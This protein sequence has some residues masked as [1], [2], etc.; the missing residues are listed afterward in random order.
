MHTSAI[1]KFFEVPELVEQLG[2]FL[3]PHD[4]AQLLR[5]SHGLY[6]ATIPHFWRYID[7]EDDHRVD[8]LITSPEA[9]EALAKNAPF[10][11]TLKAGF[12]FMSY[13]FER[14]ARHLD[15]HEQGENGHAS[16]THS[17]VTTTATTTTKIERPRWLPKAIVRTPPA[18]PLPP[19]TQLTQLDVFFG[20]Q[21]RGV[22][23]D[24][25]MRIN[26]AIPLLLPLSW[27]MNLNAP[28][29]THVCFRYM[30]PPEPLELRCL[31]RSLSRLKNLTHLRIEMFSRATKTWLSE[32]MVPVIFFACPPS[33]VSIRM[34]TNAQISFDEEAEEVRLRS[35]GVQPELRE[36][37]WE[38]PD[39]EEPDWDEGDLVPREEP[40]ESLKDLVLPSFRMGYKASYV[41]RIMGHC[42]GLESWD[43]PCLRNDEAAEA[44]LR[45]I[46]QHQH[47]RQRQRQRQ[48]AAGAAAVGSG[49][50]GKNH[51]GVR[52]TSFSSSSRLCHLTVNHPGKDYRGERLISVMDTLADQQIE[53]LS[54]NQYEE[55]FPHRFAPALLRHSEV[56]RSIKFTET[57]RILST[58]LAAIL[59]NC[60]G[61]ET[62]WATGRYG[63]PMAL[64]LDD[65]IERAW[66]CEKKIRD[67]RVTVD[68]YVK[69]SK[70]TTG[71]F[72]HSS[73]V[74]SE[75]ESWEAATAA[76]LY[77]PEHWAKLEAFYRQLG[78]LRELEALELF[79]AKGTRVSPHAVLNPSY[80]TRSLPG[81]LSLGVENEETEGEGEEKDIKGTTVVASTGE[82]R[83]GGFLAELG[84]LKKL[85]VV[86]GCFR[87]GTVETIATF[88][89]NEVEWIMEAWPKL[90]VIEF[91]PERYKLLKG[92]TM[93]KHLVWL[94]EKRPDLK[95]CRETQ[96]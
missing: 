35:V 70:W 38:E 64:S 95:L 56:L 63:Y 10:V 72:G 48:E 52:N 75:A 13:Y 45:V 93:P 4:L 60:Q 85:K 81:L 1:T 29:L 37:L 5:T 83:R 49:G 59:R 58:T 9:L 11:H 92:F 17:V 62:L 12:I 21:Y 77:P 23:F 51:G 84:G 34:E 79:V 91:L 90:E 39:W 27:L 28:G 47:Q 2:P 66:V 50:H 30:D 15:E 7:L 33:V 26:K 19:M 57:A 71:G 25:A 20:R 43:V 61:L 87:S 46:Q 6:I 44:L 69:E 41:S 67:L 76:D 42:P 32:A 65:A 73:N 89:K 82:Q 18:R 68:L 88:G 22:I 94:A 96:A 86:Q 31:A 54:L 16:S 80:S 8:R 74:E 78:R 24:I 36:A 3:R 55:M 53:T 40:L 14:L